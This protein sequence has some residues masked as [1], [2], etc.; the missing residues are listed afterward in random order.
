M[1]REKRR[2]KGGKESACFGGVDGKEG[3]LG[4]RRKC[5]KSKE[6]QKKVLHLLLLASPLLDSLFPPSFPLAS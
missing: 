2:K 4:E 1:P 5:G 3:L 6:A